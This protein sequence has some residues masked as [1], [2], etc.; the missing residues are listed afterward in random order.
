MIKKGCE[1]AFY[2]LLKKAQKSNLS[3]DNQNLK[4]GNIIIK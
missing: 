2:I 1:K 3:L 4:W